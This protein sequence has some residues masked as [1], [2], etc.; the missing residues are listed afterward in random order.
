M[1][2][3]HTILFVDDE[4]SVLEALR[5]ALR[6][7]RD[8]WDITYA[9][10]VDEAL[11]KVLTKDFDAI[12]TDVTMPK[13]DGLDLL[14]ALQ[15]AETTCDIP[16]IILTGL[17]DIDLKRRALE[18]GAV[19]L[20]NKPIIAEDLIARIR[21]VLRLKSYQ[22]E[23][24]DHNETLERRVRERTLELDRSRLEIIWRLAKAG[25]YR[26]EQTGNHVMRVGNYSRAL[27]E[28]LGMSS[29]F[30]EMIFLTSP[31]HDIGK[32]GISDTTLLK[33]G[34]L[35]PEEWS[36]MRQHCEIGYKI[37][38]HDPAGLPASLQWH[39][40]DFETAQSS[41]ENPFLKQA[42]V[43]A[44]THHE[45]WCGRGYPHGLEGEQIP[46]EARIVA[47]ADVY[48]ALSHA[49]PYKPAY[50]EDQVLSIML[51][52]A[53]WHFDPEVFAAFQCITDEFRDI[54]LELRD[55]PQTLGADAA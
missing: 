3:K 21:S 27:A 12:V 17:A 2:E 54:R 47:I 25:E 55:E 45:Q 36:I 43:I 44:L 35:N 8:V 15:D 29:E 6:S 53:P 40:D 16:V 9:Q 31:L 41:I 37:L 1:S 26:D 28:Q 34:P 38:Q 33:N 39:G 42:A 20:L 49:R 19:D 30:V 48:D 23:L 46:L 52:E 4:V 24:K 14:T 51:E 7:Q 5:R 11:E 22:D 50:A 18:L 32:I 10:S 13:R